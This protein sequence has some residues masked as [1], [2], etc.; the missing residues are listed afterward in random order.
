MMSNSG[1]L[2]ASLQ[3]SKDA[4]LTD[5][6]RV[7]ER[8]WTKPSKKKA[9]PKNPP[10]D[11]MVRLGLCTLKVEPHAFDVILY[12]VKAQPSLSTTPIKPQPAANATAQVGRVSEVKS[13]SPFG[14]PQFR[15]SLAPTSSS[16]AAYNDTPTTKSGHTGFPPQHI[17]GQPSQGSNPYSGLPPHKNNSHHGVASPQTAEE[18]PDPVIQLLAAKATTDTELKQLMSVVASERATRSELERFQAYV[19]RLNATLELSR[20]SFAGAS[21]FS[22]SSEGTD[23]RSLQS[24]QSSNLNSISSAPP[25]RYPTI[26][27]T[28]PN[29]PSA[30]RDAGNASLARPIEVGPKARKEH[31]PQPASHDTNQPRWE[32]PQRPSQAEYVAVV[33]EFA[34]GSGDRFLFPKSSF[35]EISPDGTRVIC[36]FMALWSG[37]DDGSDN[38]GHGAQHQAITMIL[39]ASSPKIL[40]PLSRVVD[41][42]AEVIRQMNEALDS[43]ARARTEYLVLNLPREPDAATN[44]GRDSSDE[45]EKG[46]QSD[47]YTWDMY[48]PPGALRPLFRR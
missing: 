36:S 40:E 18:K 3:R 27:S 1:V 31:S 6:N 11:S 46:G 7:M 47:R 16:Q 24:D 35:L 44:E 21:A 14:Y 15:Q 17:A 5:C 20:P 19:D 39:S 26:L 34:A 41:N 9:A 38:D 10:K 13:P 4:W 32:R 43:S 28:N 33:L 29:T 30:I 2:A 12:G 22:Q 48:T 23:P 45:V 25:S 8:Y 37:I 42:Q